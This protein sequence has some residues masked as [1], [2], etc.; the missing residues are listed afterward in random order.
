M[1]FFCWQR[2][3]KKKQPLQIHAFA[4]EYIWKPNRSGNAIPIPGSFFSKLGLS[5]TWF[6]SQLEQ[7]RW[8]TAIPVCWGSRN[9]MFHGADSASVIKQARHN[10]FHADRW[11][12]LNGRKAEVGAIIAIKLIR[13]GSTHILFL[14]NPASRWPRL[15]NASVMR[16]TL[17]FFKEGWKGEV[18]EQRR[19]GW[20]VLWRM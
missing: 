6:L 8:S 12:R 19:E 2:M 11:L 14:S 17:L 9:Q 20:A 7:R 1:H 10:R 16:E 5:H 3:Q 15:K 4:L 18:F 13:A